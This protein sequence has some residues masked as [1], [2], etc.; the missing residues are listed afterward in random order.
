MTQR[1]KRTESKKEYSRKKGIPELDRK[2]AT[3]SQGLG[4][5]HCDGAHL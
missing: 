2:E 3:G 5:G 4:A 1:L